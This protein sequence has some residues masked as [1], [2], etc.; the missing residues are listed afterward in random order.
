MGQSGCSDS[1]PI[2][3][4]DGTPRSVRRYGR[5]WAGATA[6]VVELVGPGRHVEELQS[7]K[8]R[9]VVTLEEIG[10]YL[11]TRLAP[12]Q[13]SR[14]GDHLSNHLAYF[15]AG[16]RAWEFA[17]RFRYIR[18][19]VIDFEPAVLSGVA[20]THWSRHQPRLMFSNAHVWTLADLLADE[21]ALPQTENPLYGE[22]LALVIFHSLFRHRKSEGG[23]RRSRGLTPAQLRRV[24]DYMRQSSSIQLGELADMT[25]LSQAY[26]SRAFKASTGMA[27]RRWHLTE[28]VRRAQQ[29][30]IDTGDSLAE[31]A[32]ASGFADQ[33]HFTRVFSDITGESPGAWRRVR[34]TLNSA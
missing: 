33:S 1:K 27:P 2:W 30:M 11:E 21:C 16:T 24:T 15:P 31:V 20:G 13:P 9:L 12:G 3:A 17:E 10:G 25:G 32:L 4:A 19:I 14:S 5:S 34:T 7:Q 6:E 22:S 8:P 29:I 23:G 18:R 26:F 28:R